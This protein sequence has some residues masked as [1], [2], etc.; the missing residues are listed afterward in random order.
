MR[1]STR[2]LTLLTLVIASLF[3]IGTVYAGDGQGEQKGFIDLNGDGINDNMKDDD[4]D[5]IPNCVDAD[6]VMTADGSNNQNANQNQNKE[7][8][9][10]QI[11][12]QYQ[13]KKQIKT[14]SGDLSTDGTI[15]LSKEQVNN[16]NSNQNTNQYE[17]Q[18]KEQSQ[19]KN[20]TGG[21]STDDL[22]LS[23]EQISE[24]TQ[25]Q[26]KDQI[27]EQ[28]KEQVQDQARLLLCWRTHTMSKELFQNQYGELGDGS[29]GGQMI[30]NASRGSDNA[31]HKGGK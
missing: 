9:E 13:Y 2:F 1:N 4:A 11:K 19:V 22:V 23:K 26:F 5:G 28:S 8:Y 10:K 7:Q 15:E 27:A 24:G 17:K 29:G 3:L 31:G 21:S 6:Y 18:I 14:Q 20:E 16:Q 30:E 12:N 25:E